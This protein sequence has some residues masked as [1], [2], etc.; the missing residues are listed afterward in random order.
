MSLNSILL[1]GRLTPSPLSSMFCVPL[2][3]VRR[4]MIGF[5][6]HPK[7]EDLLRSNPFTWFYFLTLTPISLGRAFGGLMLL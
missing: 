5:V 4:V 6:G 1:I 7:K 2:G 3:W